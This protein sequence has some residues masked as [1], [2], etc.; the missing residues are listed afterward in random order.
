M[1]SPKASPDCWPT[2]ATSWSTDWTGCSPTPACGSGLASE[3]GRHAAQFTWAATAR[4]TLEVLA[5]EAHSAAPDRRV[6]SGPMTD[7][8]SF[9]L[10]AEIHEYLVGARHPARRGAAG[11]DRRHRRARRHQH[12][13]DRAR[14][15][16]V[17]DDAH[18]AARREARRRG[19]HVHRVQR[20]LHRPRAHA[21]WS[22]DLL[23]R[24]RG[25]DG[26]GPRRRGSEAGVADRIELRIA[27]A[28]RH[29]A[30]RSRRRRRSISRSSTPTSRTT[31]RTTRRSCPGCGRAA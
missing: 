5:A 9:F 20:A 14:A 4:G 1:R 24:Q 6:G 29:A 19:R 3:P 30:A 26:A 10:G 18:P 13:A 22:A 2:A 15:G 21:G 16:R 25:V 27:P 7:P 17:H 12:D 11:S 31:P 28:H 23:R 8:K